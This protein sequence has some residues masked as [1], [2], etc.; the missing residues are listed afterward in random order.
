MERIT[1]VTDNDEREEPEKKMQLYEIKV[2]SID[3]IPHL[4]SQRLPALRIVIGAQRHE[5]TESGMGSTKETP[6]KTVPES[7]AMQPGCHA[8]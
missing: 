7:E 3:R 6:K 1:E 8:G 2:R 5:S 4:A